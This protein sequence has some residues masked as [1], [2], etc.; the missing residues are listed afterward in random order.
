MAQNNPRIS[1]GRTAGAERP[2]SCLTGVRTRPGLARLLASLAQG[3]G[4]HVASDIEG[5]GSRTLEQVSHPVYPGL[6]DTAL[7]VL[8]A[9]HD[10]PAALLDHV[11]KE[12]VGHV[13]HAHEVDVHQA[14]PVFEGG[15]PK[16]VVVADARVVDEDV[17][18]AYLLQ[19]LRRHGVDLRLVG[20]VDDLGEYFRA[21][22]LE[23]FLEGLEAGGIDVDRDEVAALVRQ[24]QAG[25]FADAARGAG[26]EDPFSVKIL[27]HDNPPLFK[28]CRERQGA[29]AFLISPRK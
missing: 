10:L 17:E 28:M 23:L 5:E 3:P 19:D 6:D 15:K 12:R 7:T 18:S 14:V 8:D 20:H 11:F 4:G 25:L 1:A 27:N 26:N 2:P 21:E 9:L 29:P 16:V 24:V 22:R 13:E